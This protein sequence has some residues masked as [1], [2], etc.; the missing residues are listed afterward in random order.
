MLL[1]TAGFERDPG[2]REEIRALVAQGMHSAGLLGLAGIGVYLGLHLLA[3]RSFAWNAD[4]LGI[5]VLWDKA[6]VT[7]ICLAMIGL[8]RTEAGARWGRT[9]MTVCFLGAGLALLVDDVARADLTFTPGWLALILLVGVGTIPYQ[10]WQALMLCLAMTAL[11]VLAVVVAPPLPGVIG[12]SRIIFLVLLTVLCTS[13]SGILYVGRYY[14]YR[15]L[16]AVEALTSELSERSA[17]LERKNEALEQSLKDLEEA[18]GRLVQTEKMASL[19]QLTGGIAHELKN[20]LNFVTN[21]ARLS[22]DLAEELREV[23]GADPARPARDALAEAEEVIADVQQNA[24]KIREHAERADRI[25]QSMLLHSRATPGEARP[26]DLN[27]LVSEYAHLAYHGRRAAGQDAGAELVEDLD[28][29][30]GEVALAPGEFGRVLINLLDNAFFAVA[31]RAGASQ[32]DGT[33]AYR[34]TV[35]VRTRAS[36]GAVRIEVTDNGVGIPAAARERVFEPFYTTKPTGQ[37]TGLGLSLA[38]DIVT[39]GHDGDLRVES[40]E[41]EGTTLTITLPRERAGAPGAPVGP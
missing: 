13:I 20:P 11:F 36:E 26:V 41:G 1:R 19:G 2:F 8:G 27:A 31:E 32:G 37:G 21:F 12:M 24:R 15:A 39:E 22:V 33:A 6:A 4:A 16:H 35:T 38:Y 18:Q 25:I 23:L 9:V 5:V 10:P 7:A 17:E 30:V 29:A 3:G 28:P 14:Q 40:R 34:P